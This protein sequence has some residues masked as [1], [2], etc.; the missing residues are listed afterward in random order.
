MISPS[1]HSFPGKPFLGICILLVLSKN[2]IASSSS[3]STNGGGG[4]YGNPTVVPSS[5]VLWTPIHSAW[6]ASMQQQQ[7]QNHLQQQDNEEET[8]ST[9]SV[10]PI[11]VMNSPM[12][13][14]VTD[15]TL[16][17]GLLSPLSSRVYASTHVPLSCYPHLNLPHD[18]EDL[19]SSVV[20][21]NKQQPLGALLADEWSTPS[22]AMTAASPHTIT[23]TSKIHTHDMHEGRHPPP[24]PAVP[25]AFFDTYHEIST[26]TNPSF[27]QTKHKRNDWAY[28]HKEHDEDED[29]KEEHDDDDDDDDDGHSSVLSTY[30]LQMK[31]RQVARRLHATTT[32]TT[33][34][35]IRTNPMDH[36]KKIRS[37]IFTVSTSCRNNLF[38]NSLSSSYQD[39]KTGTK[40]STTSATSKHF[41]SPHLLLVRGGATTSS[42]ITNEYTKQLIVA[43]LVTLL[44]EAILGHCL[45]FLK[46]VMQTAPPGTT[47]LQVM[48]TITAQ[49]GILG[50]WDGFIPWGVIQA[51]AKG[52][53]FGLAHTLAMSWIQSSYFPFPITSSLYQQTLAGGL[54]GGVQGYVLS[55][56]LLLKTRVMTHAIFRQPMSLWQ[57]TLVSLKMGLDI[58]HSEGVGVLMKGSNI[59]ALKRVLDWATRFFFSDWMEQLLLI[60][61]H[62]S[63]L[64]SSDYFIASLLG[65]AL[66]TLV[67]L[68]LDV[69]VAKTQDAKKAGVLVSPWELFIKDFQLG[70][71]KGLYDANMRGFEARLAHVSLTTVVM[72]SGT[73]WMYQVLFGKKN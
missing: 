46:I 36:D 4:S 7:Q 56:T 57:T 2:T 32:T 11:S 64:S 55:P 39:D 16:S 5:S 47:Y 17:D 9:H 6:A 25:E 41:P 15:E 22:T 19:H 59:F 12:T 44:Y 50:I 34:N 69:I 24:S 18:H 3:G 65:G 13:H 54:A 53:V 38:R 23:V 1:I 8:P 27:L 33:R 52:S 70:G 29:E 58:V 61:K 67:T 31:M 35:S 21:Y 10:H 63:I 14:S 43:A 20:S 42:F 49:K 72:K 45:E 37:F 30:S 62:S 68:P 71:W 40:G 26:V 28:N 48:T 73:R 51:L 66:S 60:Y